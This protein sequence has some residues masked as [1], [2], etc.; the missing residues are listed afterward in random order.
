MA[1][2]TVISVRPSVRRA[3][4]RASHLATVMI[5]AGFVLPILPLPASAYESSSGPRV[6][7]LGA[8]V[9]P[10]DRRGPTLPANP[11]LLPDSGWANGASTGGAR[12]SG[13]AGSGPYTPTLAQ[14]VPLPVASP[15]PSVVIP[16]AQRPKKARKAHGK[17][18]GR[19]I[20]QKPNG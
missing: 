17:S 11:F 8:V 5:A 2:A 12:G 3:R 16:T 10:V 20:L 6:R 9:A 19:I 7:G 15:A 1:K 13:G 14:P 18:R 4:L